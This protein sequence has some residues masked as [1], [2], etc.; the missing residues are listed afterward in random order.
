MGF[1]MTADDVLAYMASL[2]KADRA[3]GLQSDSLIQQAWLLLRND[4][5]FYEEIVVRH[6]LNECQNLSESKYDLAVEQAGYLCV[7][8]VFKKR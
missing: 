5:N 8:A 4:G 1:C 2:P 6:R 3:S 7:E